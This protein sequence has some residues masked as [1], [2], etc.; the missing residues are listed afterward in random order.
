MYEETGIL[1]CHIGT[2]MSQASNPLQEG[3]YRTTTI[4]PSHI[5]NMSTYTIEMW[6]GLNKTEVASFFESVL[7]F[8]VEAGVGNEI[9]SFRKFPGAIHPILRW[10]TKNL[11]L[12]S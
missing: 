7:T 12:K 3:F 10:Q 5:L 8:T 4:F 9:T 6:F 2:E 11:A 1:L